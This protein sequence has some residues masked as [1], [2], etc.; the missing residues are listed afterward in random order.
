MCTLLSRVG[1]CMFPAWVSCY[2]YVYVVVPLSPVGWCM[3]P[4]GVS[5][6]KYVYVVV[7]GWL[8]Y[9]SC[10]RFLLYI[11]VRCCPGL[12]A[13]CFLQALPAINM[14]TLLSPCP[15]L[16]GVCFLQAFPAIHMCTL[17]SRVGWC[18]FPAW[19]S[20]YT[21]V[22][23]VHVSRVGVD[24]SCMGF[25]LYICVHCAR[26]P[27]WCR[28]FLHGFPAINMCTLLSRVGCCM[29]PAWVSC[30]TYVYVVVPG[31]LLYVSCMGF[32]L[33]ICVH[34]ARFPGWCRCF[35][36][37]FPAIHMCTLRTFPGLV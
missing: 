20:C 33:Y 4:A 2:K 16:V 12:V 25:L 10:R 23:I 32:L 5:C 37:G 3:F 17:L 18:M 19:V 6:Y 29:F 35:L 13:V 11:C 30:Y 9:V 34:C 21:Y 31:W 1:C 28:C 8:V 36:H 24:V 22:Y 14:C 7:P 15:R 26:F 27:G